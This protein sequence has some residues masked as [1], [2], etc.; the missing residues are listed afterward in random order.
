MM[1]EKIEKFFRKDRWYI[2]ISGNGNSK[3]MPQANYV[4]LKGNP[5]FL[6]IPKD[7]LI[8]HLDHD[9]LNDDISNLA[10]MQKHHHVAHHWKNK[11][12]RPELNF[13]LGSIAPERKVYFPLHEPRIGIHRKG[14]RLW[15][16]EEINGKRETTYIY[17]WN[18]KLILT[19]EM[20]EN[21][22]GQIWN[23]QENVCSKI[24]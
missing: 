8:H 5:A 4:W 10:L 20:A 19:K 12:I 9:E 2:K 14:F 17:K 7:Y 15:F 23:K 11:M 6:D 13:K 22:K 3:T 18:N 1:E 24:Q 16:S 21:I